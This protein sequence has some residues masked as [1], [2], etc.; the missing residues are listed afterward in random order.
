MF[1]ADMFVLSVNDWSE[2]SLSLTTG[3]AKGD[4]MQRNNDTTS[5]DTRISSG[6]TDKK[7]IFLTKD[8]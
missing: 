7:W 6:F 2:F 1:F 8:I 3:I 4:G 5:N